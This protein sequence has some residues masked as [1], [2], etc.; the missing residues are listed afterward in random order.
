MI[1]ILMLMVH[2]R[3]EVRLTLKTKIGVP[4]LM[5]GMP[6]FLLALI[7]ILN[8]RVDI[9]CINYFMNKEAL[10]YYQV[11]LSFLLI[12]QGFGYLIISPFS[13][14][15]Y[16]LREGSFIKIEKYLIL[17][18]PFISLF[19]ISAL[20]FILT[21]FYK[22]EFN[23]VMYLYGFLFCMPVFV[24]STIVYK[25]FK[26][27]NER[28]VVYISAICIGINVLLNFYTIPLWN[29]TGVIFSAMLIQ[30]IKLFLFL[31]LVLDRRLSRKLN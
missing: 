12:I 26:N 3:K 13:K 29:L 16:R 25:L 6:F 1:R 23:F 9:F 19:G 10:G 4:L 17:A 7:G 30:W 21:Y 8:A 24:Y 18:G 28:W 14:N 27:H 20:Y 2:F 31:F 15:I 22:I 11:F 5:D